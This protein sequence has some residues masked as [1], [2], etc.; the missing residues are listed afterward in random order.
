LADRNLLLE[1]D[2]C[3]RKTKHE[4]LL[5]F[6]QHRLATVSPKDQADE[7][8]ISPNILFSFSL[9]LSFSF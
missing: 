6:F 2:K 3:S 1:E 9:A 4:H 7:D 5:V 8:T